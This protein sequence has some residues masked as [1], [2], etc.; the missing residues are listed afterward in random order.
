MLTLLKADTA[1]GNPQY[2]EITHTQ[3]HS[4]P[5]VLGTNLKRREEAP[6]NSLPGGDS[7]SIE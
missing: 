3:R 5:V 7:M 2:G 4:V 1:S 6:A